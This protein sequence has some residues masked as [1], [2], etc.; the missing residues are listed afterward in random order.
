M[1]VKARKLRATP[2]DVEQTLWKSL[3]R[4]QLRGIAFRRQHPVGPYVLD[5]YC[6]SAR[7]AIEVD[8]GQHAAG[9]TKER[10][11]RRDRW[12]SSKGIKMLRFWNNE[13]SANLDGVLQA[14]C[15]ALDSNETPSRRKKSADLPL[16]GGG[17]RGERP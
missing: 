14:I 2:T 4:T 17:D 5:F 16:S 12:L 9:V 6:S 8:G 13:V 3:R 10:D 1:T 11:L 7:L 15:T